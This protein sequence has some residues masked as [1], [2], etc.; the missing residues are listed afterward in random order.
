M[1]RG[2]RG[3]MSGG[4]SMDLRGTGINAVES[5]TIGLQSSNL[6]KE[7]E[8]RSKIANQ[9]RTHPFLEIVSYTRYSRKNLFNSS[10]RG[11]Q[12]WV[13]LWFFLAR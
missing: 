2:E 4:R 12:F 8:V 13:V 10:K 9:S 6:I 5:I 3:D 1:K 7:W 11:T